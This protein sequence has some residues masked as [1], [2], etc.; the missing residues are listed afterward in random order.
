MQINKTMDMDVN[1]EKISL[2]HYKQILSVQEHRLDRFI[3]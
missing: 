2:L 1:L 3:S